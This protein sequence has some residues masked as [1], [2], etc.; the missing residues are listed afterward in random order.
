ML[1]YLY[2]LTVYLNHNQCFQNVELHNTADACLNDYADAVQKALD[3]SDG[4]QYSDG[5]DK[6]CR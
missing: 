6:Y 3:L 2:Y 5:L 4:G 1:C